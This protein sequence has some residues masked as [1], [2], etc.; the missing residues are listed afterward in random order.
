MHAKAGD[1]DHHKPFKEP[2]I[3]VEKQGFLPEGLESEMTMILANMILE[4]R[5]GY[6]SVR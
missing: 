1:R 3:K 4:E 2:E 5:S 6:V